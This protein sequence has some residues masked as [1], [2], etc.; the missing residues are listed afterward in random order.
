MREGR[1]PQRIFPRRALGA[2]LPDGQSQRAVHLGPP[3]AESAQAFLLLQAGNRI[4]ALLRRRSRRVRAH[5]ESPLPMAVTSKFASGPF[6]ESISR[7]ESYAVTV[8]AAPG[9]RSANTYPS[10]SMISANVT[11]MELRNIGPAHAKEWNSPF[12]PQGSTLD[13]S[14]ARRPASNRRP[15]NYRPRMRGPRH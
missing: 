8:A 5:R 6:S 15:A 13:G 7:I 11:E 1:R 4:H 3:A 12:S 9:I 14:A 2:H 10:R